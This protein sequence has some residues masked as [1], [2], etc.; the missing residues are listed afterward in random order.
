AEEVD[1]GK[2]TVYVMVEPYLITNFVKK[3]GRLGFLNTL[4]R[5]ITTKANK[6]LVDDNMP[7]IKDFLVEYLGSLPEEKLRDIKQR[8][9]IQKEA[10][11]GIQKLFKEEVGKPVITG[12]I[13]KK[14]L[15]M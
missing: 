15:M 7:L 13:F 3:N 2:E 10:M 5:I 9:V 14:F 11:Q 12:L 4:P 1:P 8:S 6:A